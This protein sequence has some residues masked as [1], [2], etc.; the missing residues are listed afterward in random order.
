MTTAIRFPAADLYKY[1][2]VHLDA[3][4][5]MGIGDGIKV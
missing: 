2:N 4:I 1:Y 3:I 5:I